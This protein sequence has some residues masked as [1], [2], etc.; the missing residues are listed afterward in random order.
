MWPGAVAQGPPQPSVPAK[1]EPEDQRLATIPLAGSLAA[2]R[3]TVAIKVLRTRWSDSRHARSLMMRLGLKK[4]RLRRR[5]GRLLA[6]RDYIVSIE[7]FGDVVA[8]YPGGQVYAV[9]GAAQKVNDEAV[10]KAVLQLI[11][12][13]QAT[14]R[15]GETPYR[16]ILRF[17]VHPDALADLF[18]HISLV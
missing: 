1:R 6:N 18:P 12:R 11:A 7:C 8:V 3:A 13:R 4:L 17:Q 14:V 5:L 10:V 15:P 9:G 16:P 2:M